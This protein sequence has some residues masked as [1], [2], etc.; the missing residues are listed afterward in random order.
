MKVIL[1]S[2]AL[3]L[4]CVLLMAV[5]VLFV[6]GGKFPDGHAHSPRLR[7]KGVGCCHGGD[8]ASRP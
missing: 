6:K 8:E 2:V 1:L 7:Q 3:L 4:V 5:R